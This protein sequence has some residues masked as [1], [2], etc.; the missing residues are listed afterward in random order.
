M[1]P[2]QRVRFRSN[3]VRAEKCRAGV[4]VT[5][6]GPWRTACHQS[7]SV[8]AMPDLARRAALPRVVT[9]AGAKRRW[10]S[11]RLGRSMWS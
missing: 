10:I 5:S 8:A 2:A 9:N 6:I 4:A 3:G 7:S 11:R 1:K